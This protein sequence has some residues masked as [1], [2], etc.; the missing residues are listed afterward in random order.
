M[1]CFGQKVVEIIRT[2]I[3]CSVIFF[4]ENRAVYEVMWKKYGRAR[5]VT[6]WHGACAL[7]A[8]QLT[9]QSHTR[10]YKIYCF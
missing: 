1:R 6:I 10:I 2:H 9:V 4:S 5:Q 8:G 3:L 7:P